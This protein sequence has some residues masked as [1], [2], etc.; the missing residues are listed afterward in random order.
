MD[1]FLADISSMYDRYPYDGRFADLLLC[2]VLSEKD[3]T[4]FYRIFEVVS[5]YLYPDGKGGP[6]LYQEAL[7]LVASKHPEILNRHKID[8]SVWKRFADFTELMQQGK[9]AQAKRKY[10]GTYW[11]Y[12]Y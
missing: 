10:S 6:D 11:A 4:A 1:S 5:R 8:E 7:L 9:T 3:G 2:G 12:V